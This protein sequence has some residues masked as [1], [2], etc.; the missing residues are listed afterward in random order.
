MVGN[1]ISHFEL[2][3]E[4]GRGGMGVVYK[5]QDT[6]LL[7]NV[8]IKLL[9]IR[10]HADEKQVQRFLLESRAA[11][12][13]NHPNICAI[14]DIG[15]SDSFY[16]I[17]MEYI[18]GETLRQILQRQGIFTPQRAVEL[19]ITICDALIASHA[20]GI[21]HRDIKH[22]N[23]MLTSEG[24]LKVMDFGLAKLKGQEQ[25]EATASGKSVSANIFTSVSSFLGTAAYMSPEQIEKGSVDERSDI[26]SLG[27]LLYELLSGSSPFKRADNTA[28]M[29]AIL[30]DD[31]KPPLRTRKGRHKKLNAIVL[32]ALQKNPAQRYQNATALKNELIRLQTG[33]KTWRHA[34]I[35]AA[36]LVLIILAIGVTRISMMDSIPAPSI[37]IRPVVQSAKLE[38]QP[39]FLPD[40]HSII[41]TQSDQTMTW[42]LFKNIIHHLSSGQERALDHPMYYADWSAATNRIV[43]SYRNRLWIADT[44]MSEI[45]PLDNVSA[46]LSDCTHPKWAPQGDRLAFSIKTTGQIGYENAVYLYDIGKRETRKIS[47][48]NGLY[49]SDPD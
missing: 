40:S 10:V 47:P 2:I 35:W 42:N 18:D 24:Q 37:R 8:A 46:D 12:A 4:I 28:T 49:Y 29:Q 38:C 9:D 26:F 19:G 17:V 20:H 5:A 22:D 45:R 21:I 13:L 36:I 43:F 39:A 30:D 6:R 25:V 31:P 32:K 15:Q 44:A 1:K 23:I 11:S 33:Y 14:Y 3:E 16:Y 7:R 41:Y 34:A 27:V 48:D